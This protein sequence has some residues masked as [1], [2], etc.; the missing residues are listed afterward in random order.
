MAQ[1]CPRRGLQHDPAFNRRKAFN[2]LRQP[3]GARKIES[4]RRI[5]AECQAIAGYL[6]PIN[7]R[8]GPIHDHPPVSWVGA[9]P[10]PDCGRLLRHARNAKGD[11]DQQQDTH[12]AH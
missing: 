10:K 4:R 6:R 1:L 3:Q 5:K 11:P 12:K 2:I 9:N 8:F 7:H